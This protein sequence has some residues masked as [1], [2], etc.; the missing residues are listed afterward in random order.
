MFYSDR[1]G[2][3]AFLCSAEGGKL[4]Q[5]EYSGLKLLYAPTLFIASML[6]YV[7]QHFEKSV[8]FG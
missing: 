3:N 5:L 6:T 2:Q 4:D 7:Q 1:R 8:A